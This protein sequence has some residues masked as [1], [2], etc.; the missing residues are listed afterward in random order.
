MATAAPHPFIRGT[1]V[2]G[3]RCERPQAPVAPT[4]DKQT[5]DSYESE[6]V[7]AGMGKTAR[8]AIAATALALITG[9]AIAAY[10]YGAVPSV[11]VQSAQAEGVQRMEIAPPTLVG[12]RIPDDYPGTY[13]GEQLVTYHLAPL[14]NETATEETDEDGCRWLRVDGKTEGIMAYPLLG[15]DGQ[16]SCSNLEMAIQPETARMVPRAVPTVEGSSVR[17]VQIREAASGKL[18]ANDGTPLG[19]ATPFLPNYANAGV[20]PEMVRQQVAHQLSAQTGISQGGVASLPSQA[21]P[22]RQGRISTASDADANPTQN[23][24]ET[25]RVANAVRETRRPE[26]RP[27]EPIRRAPAYVPPAD[28]A[29]VP[30]SQNPTYAGDQQVPMSEGSGLRAIRPGD[31]PRL[32]GQRNTDSPAGNPLEGYASISGN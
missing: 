28:D 13:P 11:D 29:M 6:P 31:P 32:P 3:I 17:V 14:P 30:I 8:I 4:T 10:T 15:E 7:R 16:H 9:G 21:A 26:P 24:R 23:R 22:A 2:H 20:T 19:N 1:K 27:M 18:L 12:N 25:A 5:V